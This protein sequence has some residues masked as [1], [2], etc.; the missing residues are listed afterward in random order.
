MRAA[1]QQTRRHHSFRKMSD[2]ERVEDFLD[3]YMVYK[4]GDDEASKVLGLDLPSETI[5]QRLME[6]GVAPRR[7]T[8]I[9]DRQH[10][11]S[12]IGQGEHVPWS[13]NKET[14]VKKPTTPDFSREKYLATI[15]RL[16]STFPYKIQRYITLKFTPLKTFDGKT[17]FPSKKQIMYDM[18]Y[19]SRKTFYRHRESWEKW[20]TQEFNDAGL[21]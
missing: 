9:F 6:M 5:E 17:K 7:G 11:G 8:D 16:Y 13:S 2:W 20:I 18:K 19:I 4:N 14:I 21:L 15:N 10:R 1:Q 3:A 12:T